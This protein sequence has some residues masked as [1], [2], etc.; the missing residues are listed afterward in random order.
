M[1]VCRPG[2]NITGDEH[3]PLG[4]TTVLVRVLGTIAARSGPD[5]DWIGLSGQQRTVLA[6][7]AA[8][9]GRPCRTDRFVD[10]VWGEAAPPQAARLVQTLV[11]RL[12]RVLEPAEAR[13]S[14]LQK[15][16][17]GWLL[18]LAADQVDAARFEQLVDEAAGLADDT[19]PSVARDRL[20]EAVALWRGRP[21]AEL[22]DH[23]LLGAAAAPLEEKY[24]AARERLLRLR[25]EA[26]EADAVIAEAHQLVAAHPLHERLWALLMDALYQAGRPADALTSYQQLREQLADELGTEPSR[27]LQALHTAILRHDLLEPAGPPTETAGSL[28]PAARQVAGRWPCR[29]DLPLVGR[30]DAWAAL[31]HALEAAGEGQPQLVVVSGEPG[32][33]K[34]RLVAEFAE[35]AE[36]GAVVAWGRCR[37]TEGAPAYWPWT[38]VLRTVFRH[39]S[40]EEIPAETEEVTPLLD[41]S[42]ASTGTD[43][44]RVFEAVGRV[45]EQVAQRWPLLLVFDDLHRADYP[46]LRLLR[47]VAGGIGDV[48]LLVLTTYRHTEIDPDHALVQLAED[49]A[50]NERFSLLSLE[51]LSLQETV[52]LV[53]QVVGA[54]SHLDVQAVHDQTGGNPF[55]LTEVL[56]S[57]P[58]GGVPATVEAA[59]RARV[60]R[61][62]EPGRQ[63][64]RSA[65]V[66]GR[67][68]DSRLLGCL[69]ER[70]PTEVA[71]SLEPALAAGLLIAHPGVAG[72]YRFA[73]VLVQQVLYAGLSDSERERLH[74]HATEVFEGLSDADVTASEIAGHALRATGV[75]GGRQRARAHALRAARLAAGRLA[76]ED[77]AGWYATALEVAPGTDEQ[78]VAVLCELG[79]VAARAA[80]TTE[81]TNAYDRA[82]QL[83]DRHGWTGVLGRAALGV[84][85]VVVSAGTVD[86]GLVRMLEQALARGGDTDSPLRV[87]LL[88]RL[89]VELYWSPELPRA[90]ALAT[91]AVSAAR[92]LRDDGAL[93]AALAAQQFV[94]RGPG[95]L[96]ER[97]HLGEELVALASRLGDE[98]VE[99]HAR[100]LQVPDRLQ[101]DLIAADA[102]IAAFAAFAEHTRRPLARWYVLIHRAMRAGICGHYD[103]A[104]A[105]VDEMEALGC[106]IDAQ[107]TPIYGLGQRFVVLRDLGRAGEVE[108][109]L[110]DVCA[111]YP[112]FAT[113]RAMLAVHLAETGRSGEAGV[114]LDALAADRC[115]SAPPDSLWL[116]TVALLAETAARLERADHAE[117]LADLLAPFSGQAIVQG[118]VCWYG[119]VDYYLGLAMGACGRLDDADAHFVAA[120]RFHQAWAATPFLGATL[121]DHAAL[122]DNR[123]APGDRQRA[124]QLAAEASEHARRVGLTRLPA[125]RFGGLTSRERDILGR[126]TAGDTNKQIAGQFGISVHTVERHVTNIYNKIG[127]RNRADATAFAF[128][129]HRI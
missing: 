70:S 28:G 62:P 43:R 61:L 78:R 90:R 77:A 109:E 75:A 80:L 64:L 7:L 39:L 45:L 17:H 89:A 15:V 120:R 56:R 53:E 59:I 129:G 38:Q 46:S 36:A 123:D 74:D 27:D 35:H 111:R 32:I 29:W 50:G 44:F 48:P 9:L 65:A 14:R 86:A 26:G 126:L 21:F 124:R 118:V 37:E 66:L 91:E 12:R 11:S 2:A 60:R 73:H 30:S 119:A 51:G 103:Q 110:R 19:Q 79:E 93:A 23:E 94:L 88:A 31:D 68:V 10:V 100:R 1:T 106:R 42:T 47:F 40:D 82:W 18:D 96:D 58:H 113:T 67:D 84:G 22:A 98:E 16:A 5:D 8:E 4:V 128:R 6:L 54:D 92:R 20:E 52:G 99:L 117:T 112:I 105:F 72:A 81:A 41:L 34:T 49:K 101:R 13:G 95:R 3:N 33:G 121:A 87:R 108:A 116:A 71:E 115:A 107:P 102:E 63:L 122:L 24:L 76:Y 69:T 114:L 127:A 57:D 97:L 85:E 125:P 83:A 25:L 104:L 55:F